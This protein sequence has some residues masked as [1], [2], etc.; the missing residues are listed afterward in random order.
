LIA[1]KNQ[2]ND[3]SKFKA[4]SDNGFLSCHKSKSS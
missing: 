4:T 3:P 2:G 1:I